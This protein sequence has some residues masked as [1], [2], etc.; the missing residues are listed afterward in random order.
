MRV[1]TAVFSV[2]NFASINNVASINSASSISNMSSVYTSVSVDNV[3]S[4][5]NVSS[6][7]NVSSVSNVSSISNMS[8]VYTSDSVDSA[9]LL[10][11]DILSMDKVSKCFMHE[12]V[13]TSVLCDI[14]VQ[15]AQHDTYALIG[16][17]GTGKSTLMHILAGIEIPTAGLVLFNNQNIN[18]F[19]LQER[20]LFL[21]Q[22]IGLLFQ[23]PYLI[24]ELSVVE[25][26]IV[27]GL[28]IGKD[29]Q[30]CVEEAVQFLCLL[31]L[32]HKIHHKPASLSGGQQ[33]RVALARALFNKPSFLLADEPTG[34][35]DSTTAKEIAR[36]LLVCREK[37][38]MGLIVS[39]HDSYL[40]QSMGHTYEIRHGELYEVKRS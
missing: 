32:E 23:Q 30:Q 31:G 7:S 2:G 9:Q 33:Q 13:N 24:A 1:K 34:S 11:S 25:N 19:L 40:A 22:S 16:V 37:W 4:I 6:A 36:L 38:G 20:T 26:I 39:T 14:T 17:S 18:T 27:P 8:S 10:R 15:F 28:I 5:N 3:D 29:K 21:S 35:L 12:S